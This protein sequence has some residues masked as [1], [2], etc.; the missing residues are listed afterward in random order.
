MDKPFL[1]AYWRSEAS[2]EIA[3]P[4]L[5]LEEV[6]ENLAGAEL[7]PKLFE[8]L[9]SVLEGKRTWEEYRYRMKVLRGAENIAKESL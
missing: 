2:L 7:I 9:K 1:T 3:R 8:T 4:L 5:E 6:F